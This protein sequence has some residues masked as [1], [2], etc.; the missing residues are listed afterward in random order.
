MTRKL[1]HL[2]DIKDVSFV[3]IENHTWFCVFDFRMTGN[4]QLNQA[5]QQDSE[6]VLDE[7]TGE[8][9]APEFVDERSL[10]VSG[11]I[12]LSIEVDG[13]PIYVNLDKNSSFGFRP[14]NYAYKVNDDLFNN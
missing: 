8:M 5:F 7:T 2:L 1:V 4:P 14:C 11:L 6:S 10:M 3:H 9:I 13:R 12:P